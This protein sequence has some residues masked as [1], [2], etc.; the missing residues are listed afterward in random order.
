VGD[1]VS[2]PVTSAARLVHALR[3]SGVDAPLE[4]FVDVQGR[5]Q[6]AS[7]ADIRAA[8]RLG[9]VGD[10]LEAYGYD[11]GRIG[12]HSLRSGGAMRLKLASY[13]D[14]IIQK[15]GRWTSN[16]YLHYIQT[17][18]GNLTAGIATNIGKIT[19][20]PTRGSLNPHCVHTHI[21]V[22]F[23]AFVSATGSNCHSCW[24]SV[25]PQQLMYGSRQIS[26][27]LRPSAD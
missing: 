24:V 17:R 1:S 26:S 8:I 20:L 21:V 23:R 16:T 19:A 6:S 27:Q 15:L 7:A 22:Q 25:G 3:T 13:D 2:N 9:A 10:N 12:S 5:M 14:D 11:L 18:I 4:S